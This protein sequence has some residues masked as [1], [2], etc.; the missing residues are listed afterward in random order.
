MSTKSKFES[1][2]VR[3]AVMNAMSKIKRFINILDALK[4]LRATFR[5][6]EYPFQVDS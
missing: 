1:S 4:E 6:F 5:T 2:P 3:K